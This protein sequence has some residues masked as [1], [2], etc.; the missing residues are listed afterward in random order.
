MLLR[1]TP[2]NAHFVTSPI[3]ND[4]RAI[5]GNGKAKALQLYLRGDFHYSGS[6]ALGYKA[7][8]Y[9][10]YIVVNGGNQFAEVLT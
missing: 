5:A 10:D 4:S 3:A 1:L 8:E 7:Y 6:T 9:S 2:I